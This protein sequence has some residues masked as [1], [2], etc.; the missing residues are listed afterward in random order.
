M[1]TWHVFTWDTFRTFTELGNVIFIMD[2]LHS[3]GLWFDP[4]L[5]I[6]TRYWCSRT[7]AILR[8]SLPN[9]GLNIPL[10]HILPFHLSNEVEMII[11]MCFICFCWYCWTFADSATLQSLTIAQSMNGLLNRMGHFIC[12]IPSSFDFQTFLIRPSC[13]NLQWAP[14]NK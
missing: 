3:W 13:C 6:H 10:S 14:V 1:R 7:F 11:K 8:A 12:S 2:A 4:K 9:S 5:A